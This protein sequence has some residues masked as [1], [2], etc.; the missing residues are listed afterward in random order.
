VC[1]EVSF[2]TGGKSTAGYASQCYK[3]VTWFGTAAL[4]KGTALVKLTADE[5]AKCINAKLKNA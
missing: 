1:F 3:N 4:P 2:A 5:A